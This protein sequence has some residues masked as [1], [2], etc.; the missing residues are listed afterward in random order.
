MFAKTKGEALPSS[1]RHMR[2]SGSTFSVLGSDVS[3]NGDLVTSDSLQ[4]N[5]SI[6]GDVKCGT[7][8][9]GATGTVVGNIV[10]DDARLA[11][12]VDGTVTAR[13]LVL[14]P[15]ARITGDVTY[16]TLTTESGARVQG[17][18]T[19]VESGGATVT[20]LFISGDAAS[21]AAE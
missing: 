3:I 14:E 5:G 6:R 19:H 17:R 4:L 15:S 9:Q 11:G 7:L 1:A 20:P 8:H 13:L 10:A 18:F 16:E 21:K 12:L 2:R